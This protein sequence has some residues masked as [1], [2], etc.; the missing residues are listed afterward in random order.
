MEKNGQYELQVLRR[1]K[2]LI[3]LIIIFLVVL[4]TV[5]A[6]FLKGYS[7]AK[8][9]YEKIITELELKIDKLS[10][11]VAVYEEV[12]TEVD[13]R[14]INSEIQDIGELATIEYLYTDAGKFEDPIE[15][16]GKNISWGLTTKS[17]ITKWDGIIKA[18][19]DIKQ[20][21]AEI[22]ENSKEIIVHIPKAQILSHE[23]DIN[24]VETLDQ[25]NGLFNEIKV[26]DI[27][28]FDAV[29]KAAMEE[30]AI[31]NGLLD[32]AFDNA[33]RIIEK[34]INNDI[35]KDQGYIITFKVIE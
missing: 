1:K 20:V 13:I 31:E 14:V 16:F 3:V 35:V 33:K 9:K 12:S 6:I 8:E 18:G 19:V 22:K 34:L 30:R 29:T 11:P 4:V 7:T 17:F 21:T 24:S 25:K 32:K 15:V 26:E 28:S 10:D 5:L 23:I 2:K 27:R